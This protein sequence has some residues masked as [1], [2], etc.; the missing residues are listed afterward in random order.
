MSVD[1]RVL[2]ADGEAGVRNGLFRALL[3]RDVFCDCASTAGDAITRLAERPYSVVVL[4]FGLPHAGAAAVIESLRIMTPQNRP[5]VIALAVGGDHG[6][7]TD[8]DMVQMI[9]RRPI[10]FGDVAD[11]IDACVAQV[12]TTWEAA[13]SAATDRSIRRSG[14]ST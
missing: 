3:D 6:R 5:I 10:Q 4:D 2:V 14:T 8:T 11:M 1:V 9:L 7:D 13:R 12:R